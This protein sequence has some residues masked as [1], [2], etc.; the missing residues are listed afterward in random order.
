MRSMSVEISPITGPSCP[1]ASRKLRFADY[2]TM[3]QNGG[4]FAS[5]RHRPFL[6]P[7]NTPGT[8]SC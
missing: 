2:V 7:G 4:K 8:H 5:L 1:E 3:V 6:P